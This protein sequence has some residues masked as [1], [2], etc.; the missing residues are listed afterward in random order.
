MYPD[1]K[2]FGW[3]LKSKVVSPECVGC[4]VARR[5]WVAIGGR[6]IQFDFGG[7]DRLSR[8]VTD[9]HTRN[10]SIANRFHFA[11]FLPWTISHLAHAGFYAR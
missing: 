8:V 9:D 5:E 6:E 10:G 11:S 3:F 2:S 7:D 4:G 1:A